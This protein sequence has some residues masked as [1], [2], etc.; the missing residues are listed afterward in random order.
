MTE[1]SVR[2][3]LRDLLAPRLLQLG[4][5]QREVKDGLSL[6]QSGILDSFAMMELLAQAEEHFNV[7][8]DLGAL[9]VADFTTLTGLSRAFAKAL[10]A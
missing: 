2:R 7:Q 9:E 3:Q 10:P 6:T 4:L 8:L 5:S 1:E